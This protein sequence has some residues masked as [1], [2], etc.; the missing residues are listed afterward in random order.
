MLPVDFGVNRIKVTVT[1]TDKAELKG[2]CPVLQT[3]SC[4]TSAMHRHP[5]IL[6]HTIPTFNDPLKLA[7]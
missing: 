4:L 1:V 5:L 2:A 3:D 6:Y 7:F